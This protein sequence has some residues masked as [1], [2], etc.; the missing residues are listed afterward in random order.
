MSKGTLFDKIWESHKVATLDSGKDQL[1]IGLHLVHEVTSPQ[2]FQ[3]LRERGSKVAFPN[4]TFSTID[5]IVPTNSL[6]RP[7]KDPVAEEMVSFW[8]KNMDEFKINYF[9]VGSGKQGIVHVIGP[10]LGLTQP[11]MTIACGD[12]HTSTHG[13]FGSLAFG[14][15]T[16][17]VEYVLETQ[18]L[19]LDPLKVRRIDFDGVLEKGVYAKDV[20]LKIIES[21]GVQG[22]VGY[23]YE[24][25]GE[26]LD[27]MTMEE[28]MTVCNMSIE[29]GAR[30]GY[31][32]P[33]QTTADYLKG[34]EYV[35]E[36][37]D[38][39]RLE[40]YWQSVR[41]DKNAKY[42]DH[43]SFSGADLEPMVTW[44]INPG[45]AT[46]ISG[47]LPTL[48]DLPDAEREITEKAYAHMGFTEKQEIA[49]TN[50]NGLACIS[51]EC[52]LDDGESELEDAKNSYYKNGETQDI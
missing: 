33:D 43:V 1:F 27:N 37:E 40:L 18:T 48:S 5:H 26:I 23:A 45:Q 15:G 28:R 46:G 47:K 41:S 24:Y 49:G 44:G 2:A 10:E 52:Y 50:I 11:G 8:E 14:I 30:I 51:T 32:N 6:L 3:A 17:E 39:E 13:A 29:G 35:P 42:D 22:G 12:S 7:Y 36:G 19:A 21:L 25:G 16:T 4:R 34:R 20:V 9:H 38:L 31:V